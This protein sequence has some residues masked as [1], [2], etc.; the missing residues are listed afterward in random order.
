MA[1]YLDTNAVRYLLGNDTC[2]GLDVSK[3]K[4]KAKEQGVVISTCTLFEMIKVKTIDID[5]ALD[6]LVSYNTVLN[7]S[8]VKDKHMADIW[9]ALESK[10]YNNSLKV[11]SIDIYCT[12]SS[13]LAGL[14]LEGFKHFIWLIEKNKFSDEKERILFRQDYEKHL[15]EIDK[16]LKNVFK[17]KIK[18]L[19]DND[20]FNE[21]NVADIFC[22]IYN[23]VFSYI[24]Y[25]TINT[26]NRKVLSNAFTDLRINFCSDKFDRL[27]TPKYLKELSDNF[28]GDI[29]PNKSKEIRKKIKSGKKFFSWKIESSTVYNLLVTNFM[30]KVFISEKYGKLRTNDIIDTVIANSFIQRIPKHPDDR[31]VTFDKKFIAL[32]EQIQIQEVHESLKLIQVLRPV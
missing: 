28:K 14:I 1:L 18:E 20:N 31:L 17:R 26:S 29:D 22:Q 23:H 12:Y 15:I 5:E 25:L 6:T 13:V 7:I 8:V 4:L 27:K 32:L 21:N 10:D 30:H 24:D 2:H 19:V 9:K 11:L 3:F 16:H